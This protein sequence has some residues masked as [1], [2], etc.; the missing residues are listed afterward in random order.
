LQMA[1]LS[2]KEGSAL[3]KAISKEKKSSLAGMANVLANAIKN[4]E[5]VDGSRDLEAERILSVETYVSGEEIWPKGSL[6]NNLIAGLD[7]SGLKTALGII[8]TRRNEVLAL[9][10]T[11]IAER[12]AIHEKTAPYVPFKPDYTRF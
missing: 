8:E 7:K 2:S 5:A 3:K 11:W 12:K 9:E 10:A 4:A 1:G 6:F